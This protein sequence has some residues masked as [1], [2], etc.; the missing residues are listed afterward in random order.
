VPP[1]RVSV[2]PNA[3]DSSRFQPDQRPRPPPPT[4][5]IVVVSR[6]AYRKGVD[7]L[8]E[9]VPRVRMLYTSIVTIYEYY[10]IC[11]MYS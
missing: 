1:S 3:V 10:C 9:L 2:I 7:L 11:Y 5:N 4:I 6:M 8:I